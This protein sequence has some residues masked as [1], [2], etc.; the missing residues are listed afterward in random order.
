MLP[1][2]FRML[3]RMPLDCFTFD[4]LLKLITLTFFLCYCLHS[5][6]PSTSASPFPTILAL[7]GSRPVNGAQ[8]FG[9]Q[10]S[11]WG[12][13]LYLRGLFPLE[14]LPTGVAFLY[15]CLTGTLSP[16]RKANSGSTTAYVD[17]TYVSHRCQ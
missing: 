7:M 4:S 14:C 8:T 5:L 1:I 17:I 12:S 10:T 6:H 15:L 9:V 2:Y 3:F 16:Q 11:Q 13:D